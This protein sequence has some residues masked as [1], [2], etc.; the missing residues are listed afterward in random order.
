MENLGKVTLFFIF[1]VYRFCISLLATAAIISIAN[2]YVISFLAE[3]TFIQMFAIVC[4]LNILSN[5]NRKPKEGSPKDYSDIMLD[6]FSELFIRAI[7]ILIMWGFTVLF[8]YVI[9]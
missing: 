5:I 7:F 1:I 8:F 9:S 6:A 4:I 3:I 2:L